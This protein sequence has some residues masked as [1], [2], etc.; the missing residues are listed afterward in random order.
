MVATVACDSVIGLTIQIE[1]NLQMEMTPPCLRPPV[2]LAIWH[3][4]E[5]ASA[6]RRAL[7]CSVPQR[8]EDAK[9]LVALPSYL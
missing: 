8:N 5:T 6:G 3:I 7:C 2:S 9:Q 1:V 4:L